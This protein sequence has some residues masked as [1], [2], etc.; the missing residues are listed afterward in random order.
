VYNAEFLGCLKLRN[1][2][3]V[4]L[5]RLRAKR[6][7]KSDGRGV[8]ERETSSDYDLVQRLAMITFD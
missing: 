1:R 8:S 4:F 3:D 2:R 7:E 6:A 5:A